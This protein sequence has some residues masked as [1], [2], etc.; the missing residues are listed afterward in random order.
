MIENLR[1]DFRYG[2]R[3]LTKSPVFAAV[4]V[5]TLALGIGAS[6][7]I[8]SVV[9]G[10]LLRPLPYPNPDQIVRVW[11]T[12]GRGRKLQFADPNLEDM[13][14]QVRSFQGMAGMRSGEATVLVGNAPDRVR[15]AQVS[16][17]FFSVMGVQP[18]FGRLFVVDEQ[19][20][21]ASPAALVSHSFWQRHL[22]ETRDLASVKFTVSNTA[23]TVVGVLPP[24][25]R[26]PEESQ[27][28]MPREL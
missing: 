2:F 8:F 11:E 6:T 16:A 20:V 23:V 1:Q 3:M 15:V 5:I 13:R 14:A 25:F 12:N 24:G 27:V 4:S 18:I 17:D 10:V 7:A 9:Y 22:H 19:R 28:W 26:F 21:G